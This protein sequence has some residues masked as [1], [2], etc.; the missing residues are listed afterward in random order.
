MFYKD[1]DLL[2][3]K[4]A[5]SAAHV[6]GRPLVAAETGTWVAEHFTETL[7]DLKRNVD[8]LFLAGVNHV[9]YHGTCYSPDEAGWPGWLFYA[10]TQFNPRNPIW[11]DVPALNAYV[12]RCQSILQSGRPDNDLLVYWPIHDLWHDQGSLVEEL[13]VHR[14]HWLDGQ[15][16]G[17]PARA[18]GKRGYSFDFV[19]DRQV[20]SA[21]AT[22]GLIVLPG[23]RYQTLLVPRCRSMPLS[24][25]RRLL[26][27][28]RTGAT[29]LFEGGM[30]PDV[31]G[32]AGLGER[33]QQLARLVAPLRL[34]ALDEGPVHCASL[35]QGRVLV[36]P[37]SGRWSSSPAVPICPPASPPADW[38]PGRRSGARRRSVLRAPPGTLSRSTRL[39]RPGSF[40]SISA[41]WPRARGSASTAGSTAPCSCRL[42]AFCWTT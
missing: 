17:E 4:F 39:L 8:D 20:A 41:G 21:Q 32:L 9:F 11:R 33:R 34:Q 6:A 29:V 31:P 16:M 36:G 37:A 22:N 14:R 10:A 2:V 35:D 24:T 5:S 23:A 19:S 15:P 42:S 28:A 3:S 30:P 13:S 12:A 25:L 1:R 40:S 27:L 38:R 7:A 26:D 18:F